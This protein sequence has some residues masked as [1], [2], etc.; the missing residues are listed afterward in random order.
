MYKRQPINR[1]NSGGPTFD[2][3]GRVVGVNTAIYSP[4]GG[5]VGIGFDIPADVASSIT[6]QIIAGG[7][8]QHGYIGATIQGVTPEMSASLGLKTTDGA[9]VAA[10]SDGGPAEKSGMRIGDVVLSVNG[11]TVA[12]AND[13]TRQVAFSH[14]GD[15]LRLAVLRDSKRIDVD[16]HAGLRPSEA[17]IARM[18]NGGAGGDEDEGSDGAAK[19]TGPHVLGMGLAQ[20]DQAERQRFSVKPG[21]TGV[22]VESVGENS[23]AADKGLKAGDVIVKAGAHAAN[24]P[25]DVAAAVADARR[26]GRKSVLLLVNRDGQTVF[27]PVD[28][29]KLG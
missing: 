5:S 3:Y 7:K 8:V 20:L 27:V 2:V 4:S 26:D 6:R 19:S 16:L 14:P 28:L 29:D 21:V 17:Q 12:S 1:G 13:L 22:V 25:A 23:D 10:L 11:K 15:V 24:Q 18:A 9:I